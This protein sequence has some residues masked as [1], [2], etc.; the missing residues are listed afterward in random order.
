MQEGTL[1]GDT[2]GRAK[3]EPESHKM[4][5]TEHHLEDCTQ[6]IDNMI[7]MSAHNF[8]AENRTE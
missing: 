1:R 2:P 7:R 8:K 3:A 5:N 4:Q 6:D